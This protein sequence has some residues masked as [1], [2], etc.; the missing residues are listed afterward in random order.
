MFNNTDA[1]AGDDPAHPHRRDPGRQDHRHRPRELVRRSAGRQAG[2]R[3]QSDAPALCRR[4]PH[5]GDAACRARSARRQCHA[6]AGRGAGHDGAGDRHRRDGGKARPRSDRVPHPQRHPGRSRKIPTRRFSQRQLVEC[7]R[8]G[9]ERFGWSKRNAEPGKLRDG[10][11]LVGMG[12]AAAFRNNPVTKSAAR[13]RLDNR[14]I[15]TVETDM[16]DIGTGS[17]TIIAQTAAEMMGVPLDKVVVRLG[18]STF[19]VSAAPADSGAPTARPPASMPPASS[20]ARPW[21]RSS[22]STPPTRCSPT[23]RCARAIAACRSAEAAGDG[24]LVAE[25]AIEFGDLARSTSNRPSARISSRSAST[26]RPA[27]SACGA[28]SRCA[29][30]AASSIR[31]RR[32]AR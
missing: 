3:G 13:V 19:P 14:G 25:D 11:W 16:T 27:K 2:D 17:Y 26:P 4:Q 21:R 8:I 32:A 20:C 1:S 6:R 12:V 30:P 28:C 24:G 18:D 22:A 7:L 15:V 5:D 29:P 31:R 9:A 10:R 23:A